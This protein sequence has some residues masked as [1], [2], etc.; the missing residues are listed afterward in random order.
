[1]RER[2]CGRDRA[3][4]KCGTGRLSR[5]R[6]PPQRSRRLLTA[7]RS[8]RHF[9]SIPPSAG[10]AGTSFPRIRP[11]PARP[12]S[13]YSPP[14]HCCRRRTPAQELPLGSRLTVRSAPE[15]RAGL[16]SPAS[17]RPPSYSQSLQRDPRPPGAGLPRRP[18]PQGSG[19]TC[20]WLPTEL[21]AALAAAIGYSARLS[22]P[23]ASPPK[24]VRLPWQPGP[25]PRP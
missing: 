17:P 7:P 6:R 12:S 22:R 21:Q 18:R 9:D 15:G 19:G 11:S 2:G 3:K 4:E 16:P 24:A 13:P 20:Y 23:R 1:M 25:S 8:R 14:C 5:P 10:S